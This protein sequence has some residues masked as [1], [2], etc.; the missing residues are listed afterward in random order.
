MTSHAPSF[1]FQ[2]PS[3]SGPPAEFAKLRAINPIFAFLFLGVPFIDLQYLTQQNAIQTKGSSTAREASS[4]S[5]LVEQRLDEPKDDLISKLCTEQ[6]KPGAIEKADVVQ[7]AFLLLI[8]GN[9]AMLNMIALGVVTLAQHPDQLGQLK[10]NP[11]LT[12]NFIE[13]LCRSHT[14]SALA[15]KQTAK[16][17]VM[18][19]DKLIRA[20]E[21]IIA[22]NQSTNRD[23][24]IIENL[25]EFNMNPTLCQKLPNLRIAIL[26][27]KIS[28]TPLNQDV[29][30]VDLPVTF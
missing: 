30:I 6:V 14:A 27:E 15:I 8:A 19:G 22:S 20:N 7:I 18:T 28:Y 11:S 26:F 3:G 10:S 13:G 16:E 1:P 9:A 17:D 2:R 29:G 5:Q 24:D 21:G 25:D 4:A 12:A 23:E